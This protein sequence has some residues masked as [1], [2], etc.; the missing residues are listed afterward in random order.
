M[1]NATAASTSASVA[2]TPSTMASSCQSPVLHTNDSP[3][4]LNRNHTPMT[5]TP[6]VHPPPMSSSNSSSFAGGS[7]TLD[8]FTT[9]SAALNPRSCVTCRRRKVRCD[10]HMPCGNCRK[11]QIQCVFPAPGRAPRRPRAKDPNAPPKQ[12]SEREIELMKRLRKLESIVED[13]SGQIEFETYKHGASSESPEAHPDPQHENDRRKMTASPPDETSS[14]AGN[15]PPGFSRPRRTGTGGSSMG[16][17]LA[18]AKSQPGSDMNKDFGKLV[19]SEKGK[20]RYVSNAF[21][22]K[23]TEEVRTLPANILVGCFVLT[24]RIDRGSSVGDPAPH[25]RFFRL[26]W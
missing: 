22:S 19:L 24:R 18:T 10:K 26:V 12:T 17:S 20:V 9:P 21:W 2:D 6:P 1:P 23:L 4:P 8:P 25:R 11:A 5:N 16:S 3:T 7:I 13:L 15:V 14:S